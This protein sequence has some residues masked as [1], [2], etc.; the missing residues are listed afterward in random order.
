MANNY[1][2]LAVPIPCG[3][4]NSGAEKGGP[5]QGATVPEPDTHT[6]QPVLFRTT[7]HDGGRNE[8]GGGEDSEERRG[9][10]EDSGQQW[11]E[12]GGVQQ[13]AGGVGTGQPGGGGTRGIVGVTWIFNFK[14][15]SSSSS[16]TSLTPHKFSS[17]C[18]EFNSYCWQGPGGVMEC[19]PLPKNIVAIGKHY[20]KSSYPDSDLKTD[21]FKSSRYGANL[22]AVKTTP[23]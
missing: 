11:T 6:K 2:K 14:Y 9:H 10:G 8:G 19:P 20:S 22:T 23:R 7:K 18:K 3:L 16:S 13:G 12:A 15:P 5:D 1:H 21:S 17:D 4:V